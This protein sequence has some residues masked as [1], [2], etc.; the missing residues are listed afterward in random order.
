MV[1]FDPTFD[2]TKTAVAAGLFVYTLTAQAIVM[3]H[4]VDPAEYLLD[5]QDYQSVFAISGCTATLIAPRWI[6]T[7]AH[8]VSPDKDQNYAPS[9]TLQITDEEVLIREV[10]IHPGF[11]SS[12]VDRHDIAL[13]EL[14]DPSF[15]LLPTPPYEGSDELG[16]TMKLVGHG[17]VGDGEQG[18]YDRCFPCALRGADN[19]VVEASEFLLRFRF[20]DPATAA[21]LPL[22]GVGA[23][24]DSGGPVMVETAQGRFVAGVSSFGSKRYGESDH[25]TRVSQELGWM[26]EVMGRDYPGSFT[27]PLYSEVQARAEAAE[28]S[29]GGSGGGSVTGGLGWL[30]LMAGFYRLLRKVEYR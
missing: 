29:S 2:P 27:G 3:R 19:V 23:G 16:S 20:D 11:P 30:L 4:D 28:N 12:D 22:E 13:I 18:V 1:K 8:C 5:T 25:Y 10:H 14:V 9:N 24:G 17:L 26:L 21:S 7:A 15:S 6:L